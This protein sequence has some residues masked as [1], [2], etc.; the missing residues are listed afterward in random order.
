MMNLEDMDLADRKALPYD[1]PALDNYA[2]QKEQEYGLPAGLLIATK[3]KGERSNSN[4]V[5]PVG[6]QGVM[7]I[8][9][10]NYKSLGVTDPQ[11]PVQSIDAAGKHYAGLMDRMDTEDPHTLAAAYVAGEGNV[12]KGKLGPIS[13][14]YA[15]NVASHQSQFVPD[16]DAP[17]DFRVEVRP[18]DSAN[19]VPDHDLPPTTSFTPSQPEAPKPPAPLNPATDFGGNTLKFGSLDTGIPISSGV[20]NTLAGVGKSISDTG[21]GLGQLYDNLIGNGKAPADRA[22]LTEAARLDKPLMN[23]TAGGLGNMAGQ[24]GQMAV[25]PGGGLGVLGKTILSSGLFEGAQPVTGDA[26]R[27]GNVA[28]GEAGGLLGLGVL[29]GAS[30]ASKAGFDKLAPEAQELVQKALDWK[31]PLSM[32][33]LTT[34]PVTKAVGSVL[35]NLPLSG[36][37][38]NTAAQTSAYMKKLTETMG[39]SGDNLAT[40]LKS[41]K[42]N[43]G[44]AYNDIFS[45]NSVELSPANVA[46]MRK[47]ANDHSVNDMTGQSETGFLHSK[48]DDILSKFDDYG[49]VPGALYQTLRSNLGTLAKK[50]S[51]NQAS[52]LEKPL[53]SLQKELDS[54]A[55]VSLQAPDVPLLSD[56]NSKY[57]AMKTLE[58]AIPTDVTASTNPNQ[59]AR[60]VRNSMKPEYT[61]GTGTSDLPD[62]AKVGT[63]VLRDTDATASGKKFWAKTAAGATE[64]A[65]GALLGSHA[66]KGHD[67][68]NGFIG[69]LAGGL[70]ALLAA[71]AGGA[72]A[73]SNWMRNA[74]VNGVHIPLP[75]LGIG[76]P[77]VTLPVSKIL[78]QL[79]QK[80]QDVGAQ[81]LGTAAGGNLSRP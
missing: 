30:A 74:M 67:D 54:A 63:S 41:A 23:T 49:Q 21:S 12:Q 42:T 55:K 52:G 31:I 80:G 70:G 1:H 9:P 17:P 6:A 47:I 78:G 59:I 64:V 4:Q 58:K 40:A 81:F 72:A 66:A 53:K 60:T 2:A 76:G 7:Q 43:I 19:Y 68:G 16:D 10:A 37:A 5:S 32:D 44:N 11:D 20:Q 28:R 35:N 71:R 24:V 15:K 8:M 33:Q 26:S 27:L 39:E 56:A 79:G 48:I 65:A 34:N 14:N 62:I 29:K 36:Y 69:P 77:Q 57:A 13:L 46:N 22:R 75:A 25:I 50:A 73:T 18:S 45:R 61:Y 38:K 51:G 3:N